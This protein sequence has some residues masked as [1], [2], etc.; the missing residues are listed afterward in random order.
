MRPPPALID[1]GCMQIVSKPSRPGAWGKLTVG[2]LFGWEQG[3]GEGLMGQK[4]ERSALGPTCPEWWQGLPGM[5][6][7]GSS[8]WSSFHL[9]S[10]SVSSFYFPILDK[11]PDL[12]GEVERMHKAPLVR[13]GLWEGRSC[14]RHRNREVPTIT[15]PAKGHVSQSPREKFLQLPRPHK[16]AQDSASFFY[17]FPVPQ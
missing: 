15:N 11:E 7:P 8:D 4:E 17:P 1:S 13:T 14:Y 6:A 10:F 16:E 2:R 5:L 9:L 12:Q 3:N